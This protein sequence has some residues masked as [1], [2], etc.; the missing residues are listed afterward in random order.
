M[1]CQIVRLYHMSYPWVYRPIRCDVA[2]FCSPWSSVPIMATQYQCIRN[3]CFV[4]SQQRANLPSLVLTKCSEHIYLRVAFF[5]VD[6]DW[7]PE[8][9]NRRSIMTQLAVILITKKQHKPRAYEAL[10]R[11]L[12]MHEIKPEKISANLP[13]SLFVWGIALLTFYLIVQTQ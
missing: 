5:S 10:V 6:T 4:Q 7:F 11:G 1:I 8:Y 9:N 12:K 2:K 13:L 3:T